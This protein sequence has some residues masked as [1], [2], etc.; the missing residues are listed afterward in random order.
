MANKEKNIFEMLCLMEGSIADKSV[1]QNKEID[2]IVNAAN[3]TLMGSDRGVDGA[4]H[5][6]IYELSEGKHVFCKEICKEMKTSNRKNMI[7]CERGKAYKTSG[8]ELCDNVI[9]VVGAKYDGIE[10]RDTCSSSR[11]QTL[12]SC[13]LEIVKLL[14][15]HMDIKHIAIPIVGA[16]EYG[17]PYDLA[18]RIAIV[19]VSNALIEWKE[20]DSEL[21]E[22]A[23]IE[24]IYFF[25]YDSDMETQKK[26]ME[27]AKKI[28][29]QY[30]PLIKK[31]RKAVFQKSAKAHFRYMREIERYDGKRGYFSIA[32]NIRWLLM[33][34]RILFLPSMFLKDL[35]GKNDWKKRR[36]F[37][38]IFALAKMILPILYYL[39]LSG[40]KDLKLPDAKWKWYLEGIVLI[41]VVYAICDTMSYLLTLIIMSDIQRPSANIIRSILMLFVNYVEVSLDMSFLYWIAYRDK[42]SFFDALLYGILGERQISEYVNMTDYIWL[43]MDAGI[44]FFF[45]SLVFGYLANHMRQRKFRS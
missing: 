25:I 4:I 30:E 2:T 23:G 41:V 35:F 5:T 7:R 24:K 11:I 16:G 40:L 27:T 36:C 34:F 32:K 12:E 15:Q 6:A 31:E 42:I 26:H 8:Y 18:V 39:I 3:P 38:E 22:M 28:L 44:R 17:F 21:F 9:H 29:Q 20:Q 37:V 33:A 19:S 14:K 13:Y 10:K 45:M 43:Y 1:I